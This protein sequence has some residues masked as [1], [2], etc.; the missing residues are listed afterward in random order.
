[1]L[2]DHKRLKY[3]ITT[4]E[5]TPRQAKWAEFLS[6]YNFVISHQS[7]KKN[8]KADALTR[9]PNKQSINEDNE[10]LEHCMQTLLLPK[11]FKH[12]IK[13]VVTLEPINVGNSPN[14]DITSVVDPAEPQDLSALPEKTKDTN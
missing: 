3:F 14:R 8:K 12:W 4:K 10:R 7:G 9:K 1:M 6:K 2:T 5:L 13:H 11:R